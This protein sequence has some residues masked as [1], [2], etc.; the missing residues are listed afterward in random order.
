M[1]RRHRPP[2]P[3][4]RI[5]AS[6]RHGP[7]LVLAGRRAAL[8]ACT[9]ATT[10][11]PIDRVDAPGVASVAVA[12]AGTNGLALGRDGRLYGASRAIGAIVA[13]DLYSP[14]RRAEGHRRHLR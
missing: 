3:G 10:A 11:S 6:R 14:R 8:A 4:R 5:G 13:F 7:E 2:G 1:A 9:S 12:S